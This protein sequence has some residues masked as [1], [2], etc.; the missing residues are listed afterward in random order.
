MQIQAENAEKRLHGKKPKP[1]TTEKGKAQ[2]ELDREVQ[3]QKR[4]GINYYLMP[5]KRVQVREQLKK[6]QRIDEELRK[7]EEEEL[8]DAEREAQRI[9]DAPLI[10]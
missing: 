8:K 7:R 4:M 9:K 3:V 1:A 5:W 6:M 2:E 10:I